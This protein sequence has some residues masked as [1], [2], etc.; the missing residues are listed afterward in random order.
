MANEIEVTA[1]AL[2][3]ATAL[4]TS[5]QLITYEQTGDA[6]RTP[7]MDAVSEANT[8]NGCV[9]VKEASL[10]IATADVL[11]LNTTPIE[12]IPAPGA[13]FAIRVLSAEMKMV[14]VSADYATNT[15]LVLIA[16]T[17]TEKQAGTN[18]GISQ[19]AFSN[20]EIEVNSE[21]EVQIIDNKPINITIETGNPT[22]GDSDIKVYVSYRI[23][24]L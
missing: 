24:T 9:C 23:I 6:T 19:S 7:F 18:I 16:D 21:S 8:N 14:Y 10:T 5:S 17:L 12:V 1:L 4:S 20:I 13:G 22:A 15:S 11:Q 2:K 3:A